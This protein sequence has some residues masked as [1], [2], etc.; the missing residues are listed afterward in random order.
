M[1]FRSAA[2]LTALVA[3]VSAH[4]P[5]ANHHHQGEDCRPTGPWGHRWGGWEAQHHGHQNN[6]CVVPSMPNGGDSS[7]AIIEAFQKCGKNGKVIFKN[8]TYHVDRVMET[9]GLENCEV[10]VHGTL[11]WSKD[12]DYWLNNSLPMGYQ[13]QST[14]WRFGGSNVHVNGFGHGTFDG[15]GQVWTD[16]VNGESNY[17]GRPHQITWTGIYDSFIEGMRFVQSQMW[18]M[19][20][21]HANNVLL[22]DIYVNTTSFNNNSVLNT[23]GFDSIYANNI[24]LRRW[25]VDSGDDS[26]S[27][28]A[29][30]TNILFEDSEF[31][32][33]LGVA[34]GSIGQF[35]DRFEYI[36]NIT[37]RNITFHNTRYAA[38][39]KTWTGVVN[40]VPPNGGGDGSGYAANLTFENFKL[41]GVANPLVS[42]QC[43][44]YNGGTGNCDTS[45]F[46]LRDITFQNV[47]G[48]TAPYEVD[49]FLL[50]Q[51]ANITSAVAS[52]QC[53]A[54]SPCYGIT[55]KDIDLV[56][57]DT[58]A[59]VDRYLCEAVEEPTIGFNCTGPVEIENPAKR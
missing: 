25:I 2:T 29:N 20:V 44:S 4:G 52:L 30:S 56:E 53:S 9:T 32:N 23:D 48:T 43:T 34:I 7:P 14:A 8:E 17:P 58:G 10:E 36:E 28:K 15:N 57:R 49:D 1:F 22:E 16:F 51:G 45:P 33:G 27:S 24:T 38:Y 40:G 39:L 35:E 47:S 55:I 54:A 5:P 37:A 46:N 18:T 11:I 6:V 31:Y 26:M 50:S 13:N 59:P 41:D 42:T 12:I 21:I 3:S 19:T